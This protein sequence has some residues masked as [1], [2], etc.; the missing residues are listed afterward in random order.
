MS[1]DS[2]AKVTAYV[3]ELNKLSREN[4]ISLLLHFVK[5]LYNNQPNC[6]SH[7]YCH[8]RGIKAVRRGNALPLLVRELMEG[9]KATWP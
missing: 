3:S 9:P 2:E 8:I 7:F 4:Y 1:E 5:G 6:G